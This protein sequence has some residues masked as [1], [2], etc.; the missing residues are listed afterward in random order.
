MNNHNDSTPFLAV[1]AFCGA[2]GLSLGLKRAGFDIQ[3]AFDN[4]PRAIATY[5][6]N[7]GDHAHVLDSKDVDA[8][9]IQAKFPVALVAGGPPC[10]GFSV[11]RRGGGDDARNELIFEFLRLVKDIRPKL[12]L[13]ENVAALASP[14]NA[15][16]FEQLLKRANAMGYNVE[17]K[18]LNAADFGVPQTR[19]R[20]FILGVRKDLG[21]V[22]TLPQGRVMASE[23]RTVHDAIGDL[24]EP[25]SMHG[26]L[27]SNHL[28]DK[29]SDLNRERISH[30]S[31]GGGRSDI[32]ERL[33][34]PC[35]AVSVEVAGHRGVYGRLD[36]NKP[37]GTITTKCN[38][39]TRGRFAHPTENRNISMR[40]AARLQSFSDDFVFEGGTVDVAHQVGNAVPPVLAFEIAAH[41]MSQLRGIFCET[42]PPSRVKSSPLTP[43]GA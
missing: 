10:Q 12:F 13:M 39:F 23:W 27:Y 2:G 26:R 21:H 35:H 4:N 37:A 29:I 9:V 5:R 15:E 42:A 36:W 22:I 6:K 17:A 16:H 41:L 20:L 38:S 25:R 3:F 11:Q 7:I 28:P 40:E 14:R 1:D 24:P 30:V 8:G 31:P 18:V 19:K 34:L 33:R 43:V 32:P